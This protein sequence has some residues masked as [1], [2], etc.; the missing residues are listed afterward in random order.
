MV[1][2]SLKRLIAAFFIL[3]KQ[4]KAKYNPPKPINMELQVCIRDLD[5]DNLDVGALDDGGVGVGWDL[6]DFDLREAAGGVV[7]VD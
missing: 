2:K 5:A 4:K 6:S 1:L 3:V 7:G